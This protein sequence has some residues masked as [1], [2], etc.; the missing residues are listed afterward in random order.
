MFISVDFHVRAYIRNA[1]FALRRNLRYAARRRADFYYAFVAAC[2]SNIAAR[3]RGVNGFRFRIR[4]EREFVY[5]ETYEMNR[6][7]ARRSVLSDRIWYAR[8]FAYEVVI[9]RRSIYPRLCRPRK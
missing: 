5:A 8:V 3:V 6:P 2:E 9:R 1:A 7:A 4:R